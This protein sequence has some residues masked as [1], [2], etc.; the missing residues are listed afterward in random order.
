VFIVIIFVQI[1]T[2]P[3]MTT[4]FS[5]LF[6]AG[7]LSVKAFF[8]AALMMFAAAVF[9]TNSSDMANPRNDTGSAESPAVESRIILEKSDDQLRI[10]GNVTY[11]GS[12]RMD[13]SYRLEVRRSGASGTT[14]TSQSG[15]ITLENGKSAGIS[16]TSVNI[17]QGD[18][19]RI[20]LEIHDENGEKLS[21]SR[22][23]FKAE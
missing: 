23:D 4:T 21:S 9:N 10:S 2:M 1:P 12:E 16:R 11:N 15:N 20:D 19:C 5:G 6:S 8:I 22:L 3:I 18:T 7:R 13:A 14:Q 17:Q